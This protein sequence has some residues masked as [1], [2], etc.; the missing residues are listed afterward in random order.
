MLLLLVSQ[1]RWVIFKIY[2]QTL[3]FCLGKLKLFNC[4]NFILIERKN[5]QKKQC[6]T[7]LIEGKRQIRPNIQTQGMSLQVEKYPFTCLSPSCL[8]QCCPFQ[9]CVMMGVQSLDHIA[10]VHL[11]CAQYDPGAES[12]ILFNFNQFELQFKQSFV[13]CDYCMKQCR[14]RTQ[15]LRPPKTA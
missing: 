2:I 1:H 5:I 13:A 12:Q 4:E 8:D 15:I 14:S 3:I 7:V 6:L 10:R 9:L 11:K